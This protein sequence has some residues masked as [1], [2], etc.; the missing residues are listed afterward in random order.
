[1]ESGQSFDHGIQKSLAA[2]FPAD[3]QLPPSLDRSFSDADINAVSTLLMHIAESWSKIPRTY[4]VLRSIGHVN[5]M[6]DFINAGFTDH[7][8]PV[9]TNSL[10]AKLSPTVRSAFEQAQVAVL[11]KSIDL[12]KGQDGK[13]QHFARGET[14]PFEPKDILGTGGFSQVDKVISTISGRAYARKRI[15]RLAYFEVGNTKEQ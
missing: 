8:F 4:I 3:S 11:T 12:E 14:I 1:M 15:R 10:P 6:D 2:Y 7:W 5:L 13:H 9:T